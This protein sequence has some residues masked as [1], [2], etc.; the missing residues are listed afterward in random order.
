MRRVA[1]VF[2]VLLVVGGAAVPASAQ[3]RDPFDPLVN[4]AE[5]AAG[6]GGA[7]DDGGA[8]GDGATDG[9]T[10]APGAELPNTGM[11]PAPW[12]VL[13]YALIALGVAALVL[14]RLFAPSARR[15][16]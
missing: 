16:P 6:G 15:G 3:T 12:L 1:L 10:A 13:A 9:D 8:D 5:D 4:P 7:D 2:A 11:D 14:A